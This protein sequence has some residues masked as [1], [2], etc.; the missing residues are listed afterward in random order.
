M[1]S[2]K[3]LVVDDEPGLLAMLQEWLEE[4]GYEVF[5]ATNGWDALDAFS[6]HRPELTITDLRMPSLDGFQVIA[7]IRDISDAHVLVLTALGSEEH[8][9]RGLELGA[10]EYLVKPVSKRE[11][12]ARVNSLLRRAAPPKDLAATYSDSY[13][14]LDFLTHEAR[15]LGQSLSLRP[16][17]FRL[18][19]FLAQNKHRVVSHE[20]L[21][22]GVWGDGRGSLD[23]LKWYISSLRDKVEQDARN[24]TVIRTFPRVGYR[25]CPPDYPSLPAPLGGTPEA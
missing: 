20:E 21:L 6:Q 12:L 17:E 7:R 15:I 14:T 4:E 24:P 3:V 11:F 1:P 25:Y 8:L 13:L 2:T 9:V 19:G 16:T 23:S 5:A 18:L 22:E 10:D